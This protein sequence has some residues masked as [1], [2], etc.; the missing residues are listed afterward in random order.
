[1]TKGNYI[2]FVLFIFISC[3]KEAP[4][5]SQKF[6][7]PKQVLLK[8]EPLSVDIDEDSLI[9]IDRTWK[10]DFD[11]MQKR[12]VVRALVAYNAT[13]FFFDNKGQPRGISHDALKAFEKY[14]NRNNHR[15][16]EK[17]HVIQIPVSRDRLMD[18]LLNGNADL[19]VAN[20]TIT[21]SRKDQV[22]FSNPFL[23]DIKEVLVTGPNAPG[24]NR[25]EDLSNKVVWVRPSSSYHS[26]LLKV[27]RTF[28]QKGLHPIVIRETDK[29]LETETVLEMVDAG[30]IDFTFADDYLA[31]SWEKVLPNLKVHEDIYLQKD[32]KIGWMFR[33]NSPLLAKEVNS[34]A[35]KNK[36]GSLFFNMKFNYY[37]GNQ[38]WLNYAVDN[39]Q[40][41]SQK[42]INELFKKYA[43]QYNFDWKLIAA[44]AFQESRFNQNA[45]SKSGAVGI[46]QL[47]P[48]TAKDPNINIPNIYNLENNIHAGNKYL[49]FILDRY[50]AGNHMDRLN[51]HLFA[52]ASYNA[53]PARILSLRKRAEQQ[54][55][56]PN[57]WFQN[58][59]IVAG[60]AIGRE[61]V[62]YVMNIFKYYVA[63][64]LAFEQMES[65]H[66]RKGAE[67]KKE[68]LTKYSF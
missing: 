22:A 55:L 40:F 34:Y 15:H 53:G 46:M 23:S 33:K 30:V 42:T 39:R 56:D 8:S 1:M 21:E 36:A 4:P 61:T 5:K 14:I 18:Y 67:E 68:T 65:Q 48:S 44:Q 60:Q 28:K 19:V 11:G 47:L 6:G 20:M 2:L 29:Q 17:I 35:K 24:I 52:F 66:L 3:K 25:L 26:S 10:G 9:R 57:I 51:Q 41:T 16:E 7:E 37:Y 58:V 38:K 54:G 59:E 50:Y 45:R 32:R 27:N 13:S 64:K 31:N 63:Y 12:R 49:R 62:Q 43:A